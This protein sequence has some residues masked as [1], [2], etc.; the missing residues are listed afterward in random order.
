MLPGSP[1]RNRHALIIGIDEYQYL[2]GSRLNGCVNDARE[3]AQVLQ[4]GFGFPPDQ[5]ELLLNGAATRAAILERMAALVQRV[6]EEDVVVFHFSGHGSQMPDREGDEADGMDETILTHDTGRHDRE[7]RD[8]TDDE[9]YDWVLRMG[10]KTPYVTVV[11]DCCHSGTGI[12]N[13]GDV[14][15]QLAGVRYVEA[16]RRPFEELPPSPFGVSQPPKRLRGGVRNF[17]EKGASGWLPPSERYVLV[18]ACRSHEK[19]NEIIYNGRT[20]G[21]LTYHWLQELRGAAAGSTYREV[22]EPV[23]KRVAESLSNR[24]QPQLEG[25]RDRELFGLVSIDYP[26]FVPIR[27]FEEGRAVLDAGEAVGILPDSVWT[28]YPAGTRRT[29]GVPPLGRLKVTKVRA[30][31]STAASIGEETW[32]LTE[33]KWAIEESG[34][35]NRHLTV[36]VKAPDGWSQQVAEMETRIDSSPFL[37][38]VSQDQAEAAEAIITLRPPTR[39]G[40]AAWITVLDE[41]LGILPP[42]RV[43]GE[44][45]VR[46]IVQ[47]LETC[48]RYRHALELR[49]PESGL[50]G[51]VSLRVRR[52]VGDGWVE[53][54]DP[55]GEGIH[56]GEAVSFEIVSDYEGDLYVYLLDFGLS[57]QIQLLYPATGAHSPLKKEVGSVTIG[58]ARGSKMEPYLPKSFP[59]SEKA[60]D[61]RRDWG[62]STL[63]L[64]ACTHPLDLQRLEQKG[65]R[66]DEP[67]PKEPAQPIRLRQYAMRQG[68]QDWTTVEQGMV[69]RR[70]R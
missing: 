66:E 58:A 51:L 45:T 52:K 50:A 21:A 44:A 1:D 40:E 42:F 34:C 59:F 54:G 60:G 6:K 23:A 2:P 16:D 33:P 28:V 29:A 64:F 17:K 69:L 46:R 13:Y 62:R 14:G 41:S 24:Q 19:A 68:D 9:L 12:R 38:K 11:L 49:N 37:Q 31:T 47:N 15:V 22:F 32:D 35:F 67:P 7:N 27:Q 20:H 26:R 3:V 4:E 61:Q 39:G 25:A 18:A 55:L 48:A 43:G 36:A 63:K 8:I 10:A 56:E 5:V 30:A 70:T 53:V 57:G 65:Y